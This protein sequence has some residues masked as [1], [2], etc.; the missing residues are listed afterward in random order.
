[1]SA[2]ELVEGTIRFKLRDGEQTTDHAI[3]LLVLKLVCEECERLHDLKPDDSGVLQYT[4]QFLYDLAGKLSGLGVPGCTP[5][6]AYQLWHAAAMGMSDL[7]KNTSA[8]PT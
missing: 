7:K 2:H 4:A 6:M 5:T 3:D 1:M 8:T